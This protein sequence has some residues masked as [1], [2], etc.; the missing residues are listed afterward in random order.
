MNKIKY[1]KNGGRKMF[2]IFSKEKIQTY[3]V[4]ILT[5]AILIVVANK[6]NIM[7][8]TTNS[9]DRK[10]PIYDVQTEQKKI[11]FT[12]NCAWNDSD[13]DQILEV[14]KNNDVQIT[15]FMVGNWV[16]KYPGS[17][18]KISEAGHEIGSH[19]NTHPHVTQMSKEK[20]LEEIKLSASKIE[21]ITQK[22]IELYRAPYGEYNDTVI[23]AAN[24]CEYFAI[25]WNIDTLDYKGNTGEE[26]WK[27]IKPKLKS[28]AIVLS[29]NGTKHTADSLDM[30]IKNIKSEGYELVKVSDLIYKENYT[31][32]SNGTQISLT[33]E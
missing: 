14:L 16:D 15:F 30:L 22:K 23:E 20:N 2:L 19:S 18:K 31:I 17:V 25:Q 33:N 6:G 11:A 12:M 28:G 9:N 10:L 24:S 3:L 27:R 8:I 1:Q 5:V 26:M 29:H 21:N 4:S 7:T 32:N 13:I